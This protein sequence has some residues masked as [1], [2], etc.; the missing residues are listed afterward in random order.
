MQVTRI[1]ALRAFEHAQGALF[2][3]E[4]ALAQ[5]A[6]SGML[7]E[8]ALHAV[9]SV[10]ATRAVEDLAVAVRWADRAGVA[11]PDAL[12]G[13]TDVATEAGRDAALQLVNRIGR[14]ARI[15]ALPP[16]AI[17]PAEHLPPHE[18]TSVANHAAARMLRQPSPALRADRLHVLA[19]GEVHAD[20]VRWV[21]G[22]GNVNGAMPIVR[23]SPPGGGPEVL[24]L[25]RPPTSHPAHEVFVHRLAVDLGVDGYLTPAARRADG[26]VLVE[27]V[28]GGNAWD[29]GIHHGGHVEDVM[30]DW[31]RT[32]LRG[33]P[34][35]EAALATR[36]DRE[37]LASLDYITAQADRN[38]G[39]VLVD[40]ARES[41]RFV[42]NGFAGRGELDD[43]L[44]P[45]MR[46]QLLAGGSGEM[47]LADE[48]VAEVAR[49]LSDDALARAHDELATATRTGMPAEHVAILDH[50]A[51]PGYLR[52]MRARRDE[53]VRTGRITYEPMPEHVDPGLHVDW[54]NRG[55]MP[56]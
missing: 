15:S 55:T 8:E 20:P 35:R 2:H 29:H 9:A 13:A 22:Y 44:R 30:R 36:V 43:V 50:D 46:Q 53:L 54:L 31:Y 7:G 52:A 11:V 45:A 3:A 24:A 14:S 56:R 38:M 26:S 17:A 6:L 51:G 49:R 23:V 47:F 34:E 32:H 33:L 48:T 27:V 12:R 41:V 40:R 18:L 10:H 25:R 39:S 19:H 28:P 4:G 16:L 21:G 1:G 5:R 42:D 37:L